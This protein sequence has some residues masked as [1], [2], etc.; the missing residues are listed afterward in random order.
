MSSCIKEDA[1]EASIYIRNDS[2]H[3]V[4]V[5]PYKSGTV[6]ASDTIKV[7]VNEE[8]FVDVDHSRGI[9]G[10]VGFFSRK[11]SVGND[12]SIVVVFDKLYRVAHYLQ[13]PDLITA[14][15]YLLY[16]SDR[17][18]ANFLSYEYSKEDVNKHVRKQT[19]RYVVIYAD[20]EHA[21]K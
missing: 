9:A 13:S 11:L 16:Q 20:Y 21:S 12:D 3:D 6:A 4:L 17:N 18:L 14:P 8:I 2:K 10:N 15:K 7:S 1:T 19:Y 5:L